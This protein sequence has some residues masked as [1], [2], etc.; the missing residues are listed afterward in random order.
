MDNKEIKPLIGLGNIQFGFT[1]NQ[2]KEI[3]GEPTEIDTFQYDEEEDDGEITESW[4]YDEQEISFSFEEV[5]DWKLVSLSVSAEQ[6]TYLGKPVINLTKEE[7]VAHLNASKVGDILFDDEFQV[8]SIPDIQLNFWLDENVVTEVQW[9]L[10]WN[11]DD[12][13]IFPN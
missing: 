13:A 2:V 5:E 6:Y 3:L 12:E 7:L 11:D 1:R 4:H 9:N 8:V 10:E